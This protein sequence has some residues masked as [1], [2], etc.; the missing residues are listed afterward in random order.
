MMKSA[1]APT[2]SSAKR[3]SRPMPGAAAQL[4]HQRPALLGRDQDLSRAGLAVAIAVL[5]RLI[6][7]ES[8]MRVLDGRD[9]DAVPDQRRQQ[10]RRQGGLAAAAPTGE[11]EHAHC[12]LGDL[13]RLGGAGFDGLRLLLPA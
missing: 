4:M 6:D 8:V 10:A 12:G 11:A 3:G 1:I 13:A 2:S 9:G 5:A 7:I